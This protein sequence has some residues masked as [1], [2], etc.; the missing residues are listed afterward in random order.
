MIERSKLLQA[1]IA[2][3]AERRQREADLA[4]LPPHLSSYLELCDYTL[5]PELDEFEHLFQIS[6]DGLYK[7][8]PNDQI[9]EEKPY[10]A[11]YIY[12]KPQGYLYA[13]FSWK[14]ELYEAAHLLG[15][16]HDQEPAFLWMG[17]GPLY[18][19]PFGWVR[20]NIAEIFL[21]AE[22]GVVNINESVGMVISHYCGYLVHDPNPEKFVYEFALWG[23][24]E[25]ENLDAQ[26]QTQKFALLK[27]AEYRSQCLRDNVMAGRIIAE[28]AQAI[29]DYSDLSERLLAILKQ[30]PIR[31]PTSLKDKLPG[32]HY[33]I[34]IPF[35]PAF[36]ITGV[37]TSLVIEAEKLEGQNSLKVS[38][39]CNLLSEWQCYA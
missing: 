39:L 1:K 21:G 12:M 29:A 28:I 11:S 32:D 26:A 31:K 2:A 19:V 7:C 36:D 20:Q 33:K 25:L 10:D 23:F 6:F 3:N 14:R 37:L 27:E 17:R 16:Q 24:D 15:E 13:E 30:E 4:S 35:G 9:S 8:V 22:L 5:S 38:E 34:K 18:H